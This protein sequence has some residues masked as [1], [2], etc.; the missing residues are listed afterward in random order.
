MTNDSG[1]KPGL[2][3]QRV[4]SLIPENF[5]S[6]KM[7]LRSGSSPDLGT[8]GGS[9][10]HKQLFAHISCDPGLSDLWIVIWA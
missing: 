3:G 8:R 9:L 6:S 10:S 7:V 2:T 1:T 4:V 5:P